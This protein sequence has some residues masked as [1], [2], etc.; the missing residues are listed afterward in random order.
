MPTQTSQVGAQVIP[1]PVAGANSFIAAPTVDGL[2]SFFGFLIRD[3]LS[4][5]L[6]EMGGPITSAAIS[7]ACPVTNLF[8]Y[9]H[10][11]SFVRPQPGS[12]VPALPA[13]YCW[14][15]SS[16][17]REETL[18]YQSNVR[19]IT[20]QYIFPQLAKPN[21]M[22][23]RHGLMGV[24]QKIFARG[25]AR[26]YHPGF[27]FGTDANGIAYPL[28]TTLIR[29][30]G[31][32]EWMFTSGQPGFLEPI[33][34]IGSNATVGSTSGAV[35]R[36]FPAYQATFQ[37]VERIFPPQPST[38]DQ[39]SDGTTTIAILDGDNPQALD[40]LVGVLLPPDGSEDPPT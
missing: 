28:G 4:A 18:F 37:V 1:V 20:L 21:A 24:I 16:T 35:Q 34:N 40:I 13:L 15:T 31:L 23:G 36:G 27:A 12:N 19:S 33:P 32:V 38:G 11:G 3:G 26:G 2:L 30:L 29:S 17:E 6:A 7:D 10:Q 25:A 8:P 9:D 14:E 22:V 5:K 39:I